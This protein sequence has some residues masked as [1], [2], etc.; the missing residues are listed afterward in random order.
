MVCDGEGKEGSRKAVT[1]GWRD[2]SVVKRTTSSGG[3]RHSSQHPPQSVCSSPEH[4]ASSSGFY[5]HCTHM[6][7][8]MHAGKAVIG[9][10]F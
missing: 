8:D 5:R 10:K 6:I 3:P 1:C 4:P 7:Q 2:D 9:I